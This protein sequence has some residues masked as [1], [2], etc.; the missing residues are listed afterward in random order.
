MAKKVLALI[1]L[2]V[3]GGQAIEHERVVRV[4][5][6]TEL[7]G[8][9]IRHTLPFTGRAGTARR[10]VIAKKGGQCPPYM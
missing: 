5:A 3:P 10:N 4:R 9:C 8:R 1:K 2:H 7:E 6:V